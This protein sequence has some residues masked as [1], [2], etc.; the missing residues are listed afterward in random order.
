MKLELTPQLVIVTLSGRNLLALLRKLQQPLSLRM[1]TSQ[2]VIRDGK[3]LDEPM[4]IVRAEPD[5]VHYADRP[6]PGQM[7]PSTEEF[8]AGLGGASSTD[9]RPEDN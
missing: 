4:L 6:G 2:M 8:I 7:L 9:K 3:L 1:L 5:G